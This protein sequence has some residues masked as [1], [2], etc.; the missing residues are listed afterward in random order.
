MDVQ[1]CG[2][3][4]NLCLKFLGTTNQWGA[5]AT[6]TTRQLIFKK[7]TSTRD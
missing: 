4:K 3:E 7:Q 5:I 1:G 2:E 6:N